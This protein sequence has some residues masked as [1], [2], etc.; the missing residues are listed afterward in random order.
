MKKSVVFVL[1]ALACCSNLQATDT[2]EELKLLRQ[3][4]KMLEAKIQQLESRYQAAPAAQSSV[5]SVTEAK[6]VGKTPI[7]AKNVTV[8]SENSAAAAQ[9]QSPAPV[10]NL[11]KKKFWQIPG[12]NTQMS[13][14]GFVKMTGIRDISGNVTGSLPG[15]TS[16]N[17]RYW[18]AA[19]NIDISDKPT[20]SRDFHMN[21]RESRLFFETVT[22][23]EGEELRTLI[24]AD[25]FG[26]GGGS[27]TISSSY[28]PRLRKAFVQYKG[29]TLGQNSSAFTD[30]STFPDTIDCNGPVGNCQLRQAQLKY[31]HNLNEDFV[32]DVAVENPES[33]AIT[34]K[35]TKISSSSASS[36]NEYKDGI[37]C[38]KGMPDLI[39]AVQY[40]QDWGH[41]RIAGL[42]RQNVIRIENTKETKSKMGYALDSSLLFNLTEDDG[43]VAQLGYGAGAGRYFTEPLLSA[44]FYDGT[45]L[46]NEKAL[47]ASFGYKH[48]W[49]KQYNLRSTIALGY[50]KMINSDALKKF[51]NS[52]TTAVAP[53]N[54]ATSTYDAIV[55]YDKAVANYNTIVSNKANITKYLMSLHL[56]LQADITDN[57]HVGIEYIQAKRKTELGKSATLRRLMFGAKID[58]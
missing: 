40:N 19:R 48:R 10:E 6:Q 51:A 22:P 32:F 3:Q 31:S 35:G 12:T 11:T 8:P 29:F 9:N 13:I 53:I 4:M 30:M 1:S 37:K 7:N 50:V 14:G 42:A 15:D 54:R 20:S 44:T 25:F 55:T 39:A 36:G 2:S 49:T 56:N 47:H 28:N 5:V 21:A 23:I 26:D 52:D 17:G 24:E 34:A 45:T 41:V 27:D 46:H 38:E 57:M 58:F 33:E 18:L 16:G 43:I